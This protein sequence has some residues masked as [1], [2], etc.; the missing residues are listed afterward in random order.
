MSPGDSFGSRRSLWARLARG[1]AGN[2]GKS[3]G[4]GVSGELEVISPTC[5]GR[6]SCCSVAFSLVADMVVH[7]QVCEL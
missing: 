4:E 1:V 5:D 7:V 2:I 6:L 3:D